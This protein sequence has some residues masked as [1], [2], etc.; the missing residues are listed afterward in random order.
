MIPS[1]D[2]TM[3]GPVYGVEGDSVFYVSGQR[4]FR[5]PHV[6]VSEPIVNGSFVRVTG[7]LIA[8][9]L[10]ATGIIVFGG[11]RA[12]TIDGKIE[13]INRDSRTFRM[14]G[15]ELF[16]N[17]WTRGLSLDKLAVG[18]WVQVWAHRGGFVQSI[19]YQWICC[20]EKS[21]AESAWFSSV[22]PP[23][24]FT[25][26]GAADFTVRPTPATS[27]RLGVRFL[28]GECYG[29]KLVSSDEFWQRA[30]EPQP[31]PA[32]WTSVFSWGRFEGGILNA[33]EVYLCYPPDH[34]GA[35]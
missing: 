35:P 24:G 9:E 14:L 15:L 4:I 5:P 29:G 17:E 3:T 7:L 21:G 6:A 1:A 22:S 25:I 8:G 23:I 19:G 18:Q 13:S 30:S 34:P 16:V 2:A 33:D 27:F 26:N 12:Y 10:R 32:E 31:R 11:G 28:D 20:V